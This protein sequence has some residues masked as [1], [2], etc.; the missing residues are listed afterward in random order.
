MDKQHWGGTRKLQK[1]LQIHKENEEWEYMDYKK[2][3]EE[4]PQARRDRLSRERL[5]R[6]D[7][8]RED[9]EKELEQLN[10]ELQN[11]QNRGYSRWNDHPG[12]TIEDLNQM[13]KPRNLQIQTIER[14]DDIYYTITP[15]K[16]H[17]DNLAQKLIGYGYD[18]A[19]VAA[20]PDS[21]RTETIIDY[22]T[23]FRF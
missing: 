16:N 12:N 15:L 20:W 13:L 11:L 17:S 18:P 3:R 4:A 23:D 9:R 10:N 22:E 8:D 1:I 5:A 14:N 19:L 7:Q 6:Q 21:K 2:E